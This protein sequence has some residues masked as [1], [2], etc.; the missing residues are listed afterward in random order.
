ME[1]FYITNNPTE[2]AEADAAG[3]DRIFID[4]EKLGKSE[5]QKGFDTHLGTHMLEDIIAI[6]KVVKRAE[7]MVRINPL[8]K[9]TSYEIE[10]AVKYGADRIMLPMFTHSDEVKKTADMIPQGIKLVALVETA[11]AMAR[12]DDII[13]VKGLDEVHIGLNDLTISL[14]LDFLFEPLAC[15]I[16]DFMAEKLNKSNIAWGFGGI[17]R[18]G[19]GAIS[20]E[21]ILA[22][23]R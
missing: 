4:T 20:S 7:I 21:M 13:N 3:A 16:I 5:R 8:N 1:L 6:R 10:Q 18:I 15:G 23:H 22:E 17:A 2:A 9:D 19:G 14:G 11:A 12:L